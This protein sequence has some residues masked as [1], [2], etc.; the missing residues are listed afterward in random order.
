MRRSKRSPIL[1]SLLKLPGQTVDDDLQEFLED[2]FLAPI[3]MLGI[4]GAMCLVE[5]TGYLRNS[6][7]NPWFYTWWLLG[8]AAVIA[9]HWRRQW[10]KAVALKLGRDG[11][12][13]VA[14]YLNIR[15]DPNSRVLHG[16]PI[17]GGVADHVLICTRGIFVIETKARSLPVRGK[18]IVH[19]SDEGVR[20]NGFKPDRDPLAQVQRYVE[21]LNRLLS[22]LSED[23]IHARGIVV[24]PSWKVVDDRRGC[25]SQVWVME[26]KE[27]AA[28]INRENAVLSSE[29]ITSYM[30]RL[31]KH[32][33]PAD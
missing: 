3:M 25:R 18:P 30:R 32:V 19:V 10:R 24:F 29:D 27:L 2:Q 33:R 15:L 17:E 20:V 9:I 6:P 13:A 21:G 22:A 8:T 4:I 1:R 5:W 26:P 7:R 23:A 12:R 11:E 14:E 31:A 28:S 16:V